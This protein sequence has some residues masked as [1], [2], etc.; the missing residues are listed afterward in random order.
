MI[1]P[2]DEGRT[3]HVDYTVHQAYLQLKSLIKSAAQD[4]RGQVG[5]RA[6][7]QLG[8]DLL[9][10]GVVTVGGLGVQHRLG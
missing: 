3:P 5:E 2:A 8:D 4:N 1:G 10:D 6:V 7:L 9:D